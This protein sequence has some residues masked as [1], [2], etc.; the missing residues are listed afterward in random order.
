MLSP[1]P[2]NLIIAGVIGSFTMIL[3]NPF[4]HIFIAIPWI[5]ST[6][7]SKNGIKNTVYLA[8]G[9][10]PISILIGIGWH[11]LR[12][13]YQMESSIGSS[14][15][16]ENTYFYAVKFFTGD[17]ARILMVRVMGFLKLSLWGIPGIILFAYVGFRTHKRDRNITLIALSCLSLFFGYFLIKADQGHGWG[18]RYFHPGIIL[19]ILLA[20]LIFTNAS[21]PSSFSALKTYFTRL[22][23]LTL[24]FLVPLRLY[25]QY[26]FIS[27]HLK[28]KPRTDISYNGT[29]ICF[30]RFY[31]GYYSIDLI[32]NDPFLRGNTLYI[33]SYGFDFEQ[34]F[35]LRYF[36]SAVP[37]D[38]PKIDPVWLIPN[39]S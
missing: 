17:H 12:A 10:L 18:Y 3:N 23:L 37:R 2:R 34:K 19:L 30:I 38:N 16:I 8:L 11:I 6:I 7:I 31:E 33:K 21:E 35:I 15:I 25:E 5:I 22:A 24:L 14:S 32:Q 1:S 9:Y 39:Q 4:P 20:C 26:S 36:P 29:Q 28:A 13:S 27:D